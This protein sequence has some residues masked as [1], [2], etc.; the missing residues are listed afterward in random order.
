MKAEPGHGGARNI[1]F[2]HTEEK[3]MSVF[4]KS[5]I[6]GFFGIV[7]LAA[8]SIDAANA[9]QQSTSDGRI[10]RVH[11]TIKYPNSSRPW[12]SFL[13]TSFDKKTAF[14]SVGML[15]P[16][17]WYGVRGW[18]KVERDGLHYKILIKDTGK[19]FR[20]FRGVV[21]GNQQK[22]RVSLNDKN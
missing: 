13:E 6:A 5:M 21:L 9:T 1:S 12:R 11:I 20:I 14:Q 17:E 8:C 22:Y 2:N 19:P 18:V 4:R 15:S 10:Y 3:K 7:L 16:K